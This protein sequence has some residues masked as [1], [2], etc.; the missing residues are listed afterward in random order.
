[1]ARESLIDILSQVQTKEKSGEDFVK[2]LLRLEDKI[3]KYLISV[4]NL[5]YTIHDWRH[6]AKVAELCV[7]LAPKEILCQ[8]N[9]LEIF[10]L[11]LALWLHDGGMVPEREDE[12]DEEIRNQHYLRI[13]TRINDCTIPGISELDQVV[14]ETLATICYSHGLNTLEDIPETT[15]I[16]NKRINL[17]FI[18]AMLRLCDVSDISFKRTPEYLY[19]NYI[20]DQES[21]SHWET[22]RLIQG[23]EAIHEGK[24]TKFHIEAKFASEKDITYINKAIE[25]IESQLIVAKDIFK[26]NGWIIDTS[27]LCSIMEKDPTSQK[28]I[29]VLPTNIYKLLI[30]HIYESKDVFVRELIQNAI[31][32]CKV[33]VKKSQKNNNKDFKPIIKVSLYIKNQNNNRIPYALKVADNGIG[34]NQTDVEDFL[35]D[36]GKGIKNSQQVAEILEYGTESEHLIAEFGIGFLSCFGMANKISIKTKKEGFKGLR[37]DFPDFSK[38]YSRISE[39]NIRVSEE[40][41]FSQSG[42]TVIIFLNDEGKKINFPESIK[43]HCH[44]LRYPLY[45]MAD[46][47]QDD[48]NL[49]V[50][51]DPRPAELIPKGFLGMNLKNA[52]KIEFE[53]G[54]YFEGFIGFSSEKSE[55]KFYVCQEGLFIEDCKELIPEGFIGIQG[56]INLLAGNINLTASRNHI[57][58]DDKYSMVKRDLDYYFLL[59]LQRII[60]SDKIM[61]SSFATD[62]RIAIINN[63]YNVRKNKHGELKR[64]FA[65]IE[66]NI[67]VERP[68][69]Q[70]MTLRKLR[71]ELSAKRRIYQ[72]IEPDFVLTAAKTTSMAG[73]SLHVHSNYTKIKYD[74][75]S[76]RRESAFIANNSSEDYEKFYVDKFIQRSFFKDYFN[77]FGIELV[78]L[79]PLDWPISLSEVN[80]P[81][82][83]LPLLNSLKIKNLRFINSEIDLRCLFYNLGFYINLNHPQIKEI[84]SIYSDKERK[85]GLSNM[86]KRILDLYFDIITF[87]L[88]V[89][90]ENFEEYLIIFGNKLDGT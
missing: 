23:F 39:K 5:P 35:L 50:C 8:M 18:C 36:I 81:D 6:S 38:E 1:V 57:V 19:D 11:I 33:M 70:L 75:L 26:E 55:N 59:L 27:I 4:R 84:L 74:I 29:T 32:A 90:L 31:D 73:Y 22:H 44:N 52:I 25:S 61:H 48:S 79:E 17:R 78:L 2:T 53:E 60:G 51:R 3:E 76:K 30:E 47:I 67:L 14:R 85:Y 46:S 20:F 12:S 82:N 13:K 54:K 41:E 43:R 16:S 69:H 49:W 87:N 28:S 66:D 86:D 89:S 64:F 45:Y 71:N 24:E 62:N 37:I 58:R 68:N 40:K 15:L 65:L 77:V 42:T 63:I 80:C 10:L 83:F 34:M 21:L 9:S 56:E 88:D 72:I 7:D